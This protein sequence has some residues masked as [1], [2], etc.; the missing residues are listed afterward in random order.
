MSNTEKPEPAVG[1]KA[2]NQKAADVA[3]ANGNTGPHA[4]LNITI[5]V[6]T[7]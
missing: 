2:G 5:Q 1:E 4:V 7:R 6:F 3:P